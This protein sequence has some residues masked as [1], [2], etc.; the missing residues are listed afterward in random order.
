MRPGLGAL[1]GVA[2]A[3]LLGC[4]DRR[5]KESAK[6]AEGSQL[7]LALARVR[8]GPGGDGWLLVL[9]SYCLAFGVGDREGLRVR[10]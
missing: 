10:P 7:Q 3:R 9:G 5:R 4:C 2:G 6:Q 1:H 8:P